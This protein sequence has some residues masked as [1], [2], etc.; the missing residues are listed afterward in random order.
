VLR[1]ILV[2]ALLALAVA[3][4]AGATTL[5]LSDG[6]IRP[7]PYQSW[8]DGAAVPTVPGVIV[9]RL[10]GCTD[11]GALACSGHAGGVIEIAPEWMRPHVLLHEL[12]HLFDDAMPSWVRP[13]FAAILH[14]TDPW[15]GP[16]EYNPPNEQFAEA[17]ALCARHRRL[18]RQYFA[19]YHYSPTPDVH[20][21]VCALLRHAAPG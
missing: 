5:V 2:A 7:Q 4:P 18:R 12:G 1:A 13:A 21:R 6:T 3:A 15:S 17:Y 16:A 20:R 8:V 11:A 10:T 9:L 19:A 14:R